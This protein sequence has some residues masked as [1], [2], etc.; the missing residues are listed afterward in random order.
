VVG[1][2]DTGDTRF[3]LAPIGVGGTRLT[4]SA[5]HILRI[6]P[7]LYWEPLARVAIRLNET[8]VLKDVKTKAEQQARPHGR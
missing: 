5:V 1:Y 6:D 7:T 4:V 2:F 8:R 3:S